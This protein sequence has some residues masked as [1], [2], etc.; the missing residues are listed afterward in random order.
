MRDRGAT[1]E[2]LLAK[3]RQENVVY[4]LSTYDIQ[5]L[6]ASGVSEEVIA[7]ML[8]AGHDGRTPT[9]LPTP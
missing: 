4:S 2:E 1:N 3:V 8:G 9:P 7:A 6:R 5:K